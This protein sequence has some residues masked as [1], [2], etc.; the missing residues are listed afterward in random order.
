M[1]AWTWTS[2]GGES[3]K[4][5]YEPGNWGDLLKGAWVLAVLDAM[6]EKGP[7]TYLDCFAG[8]PVYPLVPATEKRLG[9]LKSCALLD[10]CQPF[11]ASRQWPSAAVLAAEQ[12]GD[13]SQVQVVEADPE[14]RDEYVGAPH[15]T[16]SP[17]ACGWDALRG[18]RP[19]ANGLV[20]VDPYDFLS[21]WQEQLEAVVRAAE[22][23]S[24]L[25]YVYNR[26][27]RGHEQMRQYRAFRNRLEDLWQGRV[28]RI[29]RVGADAFLPRA[30]HEMVFLP[31]GGEED[32]GLLERLEA[33]ALAIAEAL[34]RGAVLEC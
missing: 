22:T 1:G 25:L 9:L 16:V 24:V 5:L 30:H 10:C 17:L 31:A 3:A 8:A 11:L 2:K 32:A 14:R 6:L 27:A 26:A 18:A 7:V 34:S 29:A 23:T 21:D 13:A 19:G 33:E 15:V 12:I 4:L 20:L 28:K